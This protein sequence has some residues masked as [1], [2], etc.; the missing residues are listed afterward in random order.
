M[1]VA[2]YKRFFRFPEKSSENVFKDKFYV[3]KAPGFDKLFSA[4]NKT[5]IIGENVKDKDVILTTLGTTY[6]LSS[7]KT[8]VRKNGTVIDESI[9]PALGTVETI[10]IEKVP[11][12]K[13]PVT[14]KP[15]SYLTSS[16]EKPTSDDS[17]SLAN[18]FSYLFTSDNDEDFDNSNNVYSNSFQP[19][20]TIPPFRNIS[21]DVPKWDDLLFSDLTSANDS[22]PDTKYE[23]FALNRVNLTTPAS[24]P[25]TTTEYF[26]VKSTLSTTLL[27]P[28]TLRPFQSYSNERIT[29]TI[30]AS[31]R[32]TTS[33]TLPPP[34]TEPL[35]THKIAPVT[36][37]NHPLSDDQKYVVNPIDID[38]MKKH[39]SEGVMEIFAKPTL[40][41]INGLLKLAGCNIYGRMY[42][43]GKI[44]AELSTPCLEC[45][46]TEIGV[47]CTPLSC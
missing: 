3:E 23:N 1:I 27:R 46:C 2:S 20:S 21:I 24:I 7:N 39:H 45:K 38:K 22:L 35:V 44:I 14:A 32:E 19:E 8:N 31:S 11:S 28:T 37:K 40:P 47:S 16:S 36:L 25:S 34:T 12:S 33:T 9:V 18:V 26:K 15:Y 41:N 17:F 5:T 42:R 29:S 10:R 30:R 6:N 4:Q 13:N 43:V